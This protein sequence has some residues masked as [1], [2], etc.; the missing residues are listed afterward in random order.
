MSYGF[1]FFYGTVQFEIAAAADIAVRL[2]KEE[3][4]LE[5]QDV[6][7]ALAAMRMGAKEKTSK[8]IQKLGKLTA[9]ANP[10]LGS[11]WLKEV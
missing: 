5:D 4:P 6:E 9:V 2:Y 8:L 1:F 3:T 10:N 7:G 11:E